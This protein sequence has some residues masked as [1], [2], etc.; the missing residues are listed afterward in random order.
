MINEHSA[1]LDEIV[2]PDELV[3]Q[4]PNK[5]TKTQIIWIL[6]NRHKNGLEKTGAVSVVS[7]R[8]YIHKPTFTAWFL[9][10]KN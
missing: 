5:F 1:S 3:E 9:A 2:T 4:Y 7:R 6:R 8:F 10:Q